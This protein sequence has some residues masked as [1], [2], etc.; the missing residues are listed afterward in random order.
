[1]D[2]LHVKYIEP[3]LDIHQ[4]RNMLEIGVLEGRHTYSLLSWCKLN[5]SKLVSVDPTPWQGQ[6]PSHLKT[7]YKGYRYKRGHKSEAEFIVPKFIEQVFSEKLEG[8]WECSKSLSLNYLEHCNEVF[9][10]VFIDGDHNY[11][12]VLNELKLISKVLTD[13]GCIFIHDTANPSCA[14]KDYYYDVSTLP[15]NLDIGKQGVVTAIDDFLSLFPNY[16]LQILTE[17]FN[18]L[19]IIRHD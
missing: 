8:F 17:E 5:G 9:D 19:G 4:P 15:N 13:K 1:M 16:S 6:I 10:V 11:Y 14:Y 18:G 3:I 2:Q 12:T 7:G